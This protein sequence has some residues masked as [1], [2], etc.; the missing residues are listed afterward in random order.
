MWWRKARRRRDVERFVAG[1]PEP[2]RG[3]CV[4]LSDCRRGI[5]GSVAPADLVQMGARPASAVP[6]SCDPRAID[7][8]IELLDAEPAIVMVPMLRTALVS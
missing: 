2:A 6:A 4:A 8:K 3:V 1:V 5:R 7:R